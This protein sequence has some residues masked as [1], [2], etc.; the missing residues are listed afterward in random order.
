MPRSASTLL[1]Y[2]GG[3]AGPLRLK[4]EPR[5]IS[6]QPILFVH[7]D[8]DDYTPIA[9]CLDYAEKIH[10]SGIPVRFEALRGARHTFDSYDPGRH[11]Y[12]NV[13]VPRADCPIELDIRTLQ[14]FDRVSGARLTGEA[15]RIAR[16]A[17]QTRG[18]SAEGSRSS[19]RKAA[20]AVIQFLRSPP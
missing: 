16:E 18:G 19:R 2:T 9:P 20:E 12:R 13:T 3:C 6:P 14:S 10:A 8:E 11:H 17:C 15:H 1:L 4:V 5:F 7:G